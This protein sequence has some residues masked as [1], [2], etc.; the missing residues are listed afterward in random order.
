MA[1]LSRDA[2]GNH[3]VQVVCGDGKRRS[4]RL[5]VV[6]KKVAESIKLKVEHLNALVVAR[7]PMDAETAGWVGS[8]GDDLAA[9]LA[10]VGLIPSRQSARLGEFLDDYLD[11]RRHE[12][13]GGTVT[14][15]RQTVND[16]IRFF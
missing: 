16:L 1:S 4:I 7:L 12:L 5:G 11:R 3:T 14:T 10:A 8:I 15:Q 13:K 2:S 9:K 6:P